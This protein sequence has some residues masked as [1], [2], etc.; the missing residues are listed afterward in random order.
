[1]TVALHVDAVK[2]MAFA[3]KGLADVM[4]GARF[5]GRERGVT[6]SMKLWALKGLTRS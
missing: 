3:T 1:M 4:M 2:T 6:V 5:T